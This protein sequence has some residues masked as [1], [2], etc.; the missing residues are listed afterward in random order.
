ML[1]RLERLGVICDDWSLLHLD[2]SRLSYVKEERVGTLD[3]RLKPPA[4]VSSS[5]GCSG[6]APKA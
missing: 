5:E 6:A 4:M 3:H 2:R 1:P